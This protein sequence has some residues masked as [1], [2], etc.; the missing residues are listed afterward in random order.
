MHR[1]RTSSLIAGR[2]VP[3]P[4]WN[5]PPTRPSPP[6]SLRLVTWNVNS[7]TYSQL[8]LRCILTYLGTLI[9]P[10]GV[11]PIEPCCILLQEVSLNALDFLLTMDWVL[12][13]FLIIPAGS[14]QW[15]RGAQYGN[16]TLI[17]KNIP[18]VAGQWLDFAASSMGRNA[19]I[20]DVAVRHSQSGRTLTLRIANTHLES[21]P[22]N[23]LIRAAQLS[24]IAEKL[25]RPTVHG[26]VVAGDMNAICP[27][28]QVIH[29]QAG[30]VDAHPGPEN[31]RSF[32]WGYQPRTAF[33]PGRLDRM[34]FTPQRMSWDSVQLKV[35]EPS[36]IGMGLQAGNLW[37]SDHYG[38][39]STVRFL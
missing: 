16:V 29:R 12:N 15:P 17:S 3:Q 8:R 1:R 39:M 27:N 31:E 22:E 20:T 32:T 37:A 11:G 25:R 36:R 13:D 7:A 24:Y 33:P 21:L 23:A 38:L 30:L 9:R 26:G 18:F 14:V 5:S 35:D 6:S 28:D 10:H 4:I 19:L 2:T 34:Y